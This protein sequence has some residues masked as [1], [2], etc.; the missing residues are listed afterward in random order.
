MAEIEA[1]RERLRGVAVRTPLLPLHTHD[2][3]RDILLKPELLQPI[4]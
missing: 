3:R 2:N 4:G 1:A